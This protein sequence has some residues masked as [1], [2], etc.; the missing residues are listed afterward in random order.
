MIKR[1]LVRMTISYFACS[2]Y[3]GVLYGLARYR[4]Y[5]DIDRQLVFN[6]DHMYQISL[7]NGA[8]VINIDSKEPERL[9]KDKNIDPLKVAI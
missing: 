3:W 5:S 6:I 7:S 8:Q 2:S 1:T 9:S 4:I